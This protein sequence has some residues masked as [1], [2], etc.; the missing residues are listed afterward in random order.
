MHVI[1]QTL[2]SLYA[3]DDLVGISREELVEAIP[4]LM[5]SV[6]SKT[7]WCP[8]RTYQESLV[9]FSRAVYALRLEGGRCERAVGLAGCG[10]YDPNGI[11]PV[12]QVEE[13]HYK[14]E[15]MDFHSG[16]A[17]SYGMAFVEIILDPGVQGRSLELSF[18]TPEGGAA[19]FSVQVWKLRGDE[20][21]RLVSV[22]A[23]E[24]S[25]D[26]LVSDLE[27]RRAFYP[28]E[29]IDRGSY[30]RLGLVITRLDSRENQDPVGAFTISLQPAA[31]VL[32]GKGD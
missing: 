1:R 16:I 28:I 17:G 32:Q 15:E 10:F 8:F 23:P 11:Y 14:G 4:G 2:N 19:E 29:R 26:V 21:G 22:P 27:R 5:N 20:N 25:P 30:E 3:S 18:E 7:A 13:I 12:P 24:N 9:A 31:K 6:L